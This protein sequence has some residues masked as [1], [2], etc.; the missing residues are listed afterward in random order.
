MA[1]FET[2]NQVVLTC[3]VIWCEQEWPPPVS[4]PTRWNGDWGQRGGMT[5]WEAYPTLR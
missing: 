4:V 5:A 3:L 2:S 1:H